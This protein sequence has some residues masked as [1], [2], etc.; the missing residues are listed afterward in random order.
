MFLYE[1]NLRRERVKNVGGIVQSGLTCVR[2]SNVGSNEGMST[3]QCT[4]TGTRTMVLLAVVTSNDQAIS[5]V[6]SINA[7]HILQYLCL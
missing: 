5:G 3:Q 1:T 6:T 4:K 2:G 7:V